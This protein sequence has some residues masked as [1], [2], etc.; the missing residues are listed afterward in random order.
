MQ[1]KHY[2]CLYI[3]V[4][5][6]PLETLFLFLGPTYQRH[7][8]SAEGITAGR[9]PRKPGPAQMD[10]PGENQWP[11]IV[12][13]SNSTKSNFSFQMFLLLKKKFTEV[14]LK[15]LDSVRSVYRQLVLKHIIIILR[16]KKGVY[17][18]KECIQEKKGIH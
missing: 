16:C 11:V 2:Y 9:M 7:R 3:W 14:P 12:H 17:L 15:H 18:N 8:A 6:N 10:G 1:H 4:Q 13:R 5:K